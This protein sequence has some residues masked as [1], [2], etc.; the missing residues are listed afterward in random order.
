MSKISYVIGDIGEMKWQNRRIFA[1]RH[2]KTSCVILI[3]NMIT[4]TKRVFYGHARICPIK[5]LICAF[6]KTVI[7]QT[8]VILL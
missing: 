5:G 1:D 8:S 7:H 4:L 3:E 6:F 2:L